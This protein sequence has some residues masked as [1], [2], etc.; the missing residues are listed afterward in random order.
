MSRSRKKCKESSVLTAFSHRTRLAREEYILA[1]LIRENQPEDR[2][3]L[4]EAKP[5]YKNLKKAR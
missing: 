2:V 4:K 3:S 5:F 1:K